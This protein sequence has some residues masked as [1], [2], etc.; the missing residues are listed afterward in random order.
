MPV[1]HNLHDAEIEHVERTTR[2]IDEELVSLEDFHKPL[3]VQ[4]NA[5]YLGTL[6]TTVSTSTQATTPQKAPPF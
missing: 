3:A 4:T 1:Y 2:S 5:R 6:S